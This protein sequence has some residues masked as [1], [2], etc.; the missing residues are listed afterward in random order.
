MK[1]YWS[2]TNDDSFMDL[3]CNFDFTCPFHGEGSTMVLHDSKLF[4]FNLDKDKERDLSH[5]ID[6]VVRCPDCGYIDIYGVAVSDEHYGRI[7]ER[8]ERYINVLIQEAKQRKI[9]ESPAVATN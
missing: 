5:A 1:T 6:V 7:Y 9:D 4:K 8:I 3:Q 2:E